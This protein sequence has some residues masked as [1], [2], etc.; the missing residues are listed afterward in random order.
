[1]AELHE[2]LMGRK[3]IEGVLPNIADQLKRI[4]DALESNKKPDEM[5]SAFK[6]YVNQFPNDVELGAKIRELWQK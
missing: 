2:T 6:T 4:A 5:T 1:M 3:L